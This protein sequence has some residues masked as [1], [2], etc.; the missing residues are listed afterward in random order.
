MKKR[1]GYSLDEILLAVCR[2]L[3][4]KKMGAA[5]GI[6]IKLGINPKTAQKYLTMGV[7]LGILLSDELYE[8]KDGRKCMA[9]RINPKYME[10][11]KEII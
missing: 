3:E 11:M 4:N 7:N 2:Y 9:Y 8:S 10:I 5:S 1:K 6:A